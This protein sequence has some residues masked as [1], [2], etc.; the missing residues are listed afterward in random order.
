[1]IEDFLSELN[2]PLRT[3]KLL[4][5]LIQEHIH[6]EFTFFIDKN[7]L[8]KNENTL[9]ISYAI[10]LVN[11]DIAKLYDEYYKKMCEEKYKNQSI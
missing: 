5:L 10:E 4:N 6:D 7:Q 11:E 8:D 1:M 2:K 3:I 9:A